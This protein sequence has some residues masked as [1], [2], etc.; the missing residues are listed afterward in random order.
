MCNQCKDVLEIVTCPV[1]QC[2]QNDD[3]IHG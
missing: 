2:N 1:E 3:A